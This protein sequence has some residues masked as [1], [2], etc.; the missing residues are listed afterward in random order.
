L[1]SLFGSSFLFGNDGK[2]YVFRAPF[3][4]GNY[5]IP[6]NII[7]SLENYIVSLCEVRK[8]Y[9]IA[10]LELL[11]VSID[12]MEAV[13]EAFETENSALIEQAKIITVNVDLA[14]NL[15]NYCKSNNDYKQATDTEEDRT[16]Y[17]I[18]V[19]LIMWDAFWKRLVWRRLIGRRFGFP[20][21]KVMIEK[22]ME[23]ESI[24]VKYTLI[25]VQSR[26]IC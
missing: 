1:L 13:F 14:M 9:E 24:Y 7:I 20:K 8:I 2:G 23:S 12:E 4:S 5:Q 17:L 10:S 19:F 15:I 11:G 3:I 21:D 26:R 22:Y 18:R 25:Y 16:Y 6:P